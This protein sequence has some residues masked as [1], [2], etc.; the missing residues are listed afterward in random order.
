M[1]NIIALNSAV[2]S[3]FQMIAAT[4]D[5]AAGGSVI[6]QITSATA[7]AMDVQARIDGQPDSTAADI[8][9]YNMLS[10]PATKVA[11]GTDITA[12]GIYGVKAPGL[13]VGL[14][15]AAGTAQC[16]VRAIEGTF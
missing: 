5:A 6:F 2:S 15:V 4:G 12:N 10:D 14:K 11:T 7:L 8:V 16:T 13:V 1:A 3:A 9:Y